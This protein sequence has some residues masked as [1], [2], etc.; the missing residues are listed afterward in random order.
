MKCI[1]NLPA[2]DGLFPVG[3]GR[4]YV[5][6]DYHSKPLGMLK[7]A[8]AGAPVKRLSSAEIMEAIK[9]KTAARSWVTDLCDRVGSHVKNQQS[10]NY[11]WGHAPCRGMEC[12]YVFSGGSPFVLAAFDPCAAIMGGSNSGGSGITWVE[13][14]AQNGVCVEALHKPMDFSSR[15]TPEQAANAALHKIDAFDDLDPSDHELIASYIINDVPVTVGV[16][17]WWHEVLLTFLV[18]EG[19]DWYFGFDNSWS[20]SYGENG[21]AVL[22]GAYSRFDEAGA[23]RS[24]TP[25]AT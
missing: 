3:Y 9:A 16:P 18:I 19:S 23:I 4:G 2:V 24:V 22:H 15:R 8:K 20:T 11:C 17:A 13:W 7:F 14:V 6:R 12:Q 5:P 1:A 21:R 25:S 10:S